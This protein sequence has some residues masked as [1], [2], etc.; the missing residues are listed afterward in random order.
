MDRV[1]GGTSR[2]VL[3]V[4]LSLVALVPIITGSTNAL[5]GTAMVPDHPPAYADVESNYRFFAAIWV[6]AGFFLLWIVPR[7]ERATGPMRAISSAIFVA[8]LVRLTSTLVVGAPHPRFLV[9][10]AVE[11]L[12]PP[13]LVLWQSR[14]A[15]SA[16]LDPG[17]SVEPAGQDAVDAGR[18]P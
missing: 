1:P 3:Q 11:L 12:A 15:A 6:S 10:N 18:L 14:V 5:G 7:V 9:L 4:V 13:I 2:R 16:A 17:R 8:G